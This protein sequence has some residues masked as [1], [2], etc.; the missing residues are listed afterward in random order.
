MIS[1]FKLPCSLRPKSGTEL[2]ARSHITRRNGAKLPTVDAAGKLDV[3]SSALSKKQRSGRQEED[4]IM[5]CKTSSHSVSSFT[6]LDQLDG[7]VVAHAVSGGRMIRKGAIVV[8]GGKG[9]LGHPC[10]A[11]VVR[12]SGPRSIVR[13]FRKW[14]VDGDTDSDAPG[15]IPQTYH[16]FW[17]LPSDRGLLDDVGTIDNSQVTFVTYKSVLRVDCES[18]LVCLP[19]GFFDKISALHY[20]WHLPESDMSAVVDHL[21]TEAA[22]AANSRDCL[23]DAR[24]L[25]CAHENTPAPQALPPPPLLE[26][27]SLLAGSDLINGP[28]RPWDPWGSL[29]EAQMSAMLDDI[30]SHAETHCVC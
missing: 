9:V 6:L 3:E 12:K 11:E 15:L 21:L 25:Q 10:L 5:T 1:R 8:I 19:R 16:K 27:T 24:Q 29:T 2:E 23:G 30:V 26:D 28:Q 14:G 20:H 17:Y 13:Y 4:K 22:A 18:G 7:K